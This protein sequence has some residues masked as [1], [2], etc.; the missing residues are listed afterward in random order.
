M[1]TRK[2]PS[3]PIGKSKDQSGTD[4]LE[5]LVSMAKRRGKGRRDHSTPSPTA[6]SRFGAGA[7]SY[8]AQDSLS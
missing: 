7:S 8:G 1:R 4:D 2:S 3:G 6:P 5:L